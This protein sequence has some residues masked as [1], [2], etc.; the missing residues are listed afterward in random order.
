MLKKL[1]K[2]EWKAIWKV[3]LVINIFT[4]LATLMG[5]FI[6]HVIDL[7]NIP[8]S[9]KLVT[10]LTVIFYYLTIAGVSLAMSLYIAIRFY[11][12]LYTDEG[13][14]MH[15][16]PVTA[17][18]LVLSRLLVHSFCL[19]LTGTLVAFSIFVVLL[20][21]LEQI[22]DG[23]AVSFSGLTF[24]TLI[25]ALDIECRNNL[26]I[27]PLLFVLFIAIAYVIS[28][29][30]GI[31]SIYCAIALGQSFRHRILGSVICYVAIYYLQQMISSIVTVPQVLKQLSEFN[32]V[33]Y[34]FNLFFTISL[35][36]LPIGILFYL[37]ILY[38]IDKRLNLA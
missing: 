35:L 16:L 4:A 19:L 13:Y 37:V 5:F 28:A 23:S 3:T 8:S 24:S 27:S 26:H 20:P 10:I 25:A 31:L 11:R 9:A 17:R 34:V 18:Q 33:T 14:L 7:D 12:S 22:F 2:Y 6:T 38:R 1:M 36:F 30:C 21:L 15:T 32:S 29:F